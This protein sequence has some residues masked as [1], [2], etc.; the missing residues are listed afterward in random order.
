MTEKSLNLEIG[1][2][3]FTAIMLK[4]LIK[5]LDGLISMSTYLCSCWLCI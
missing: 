1:T 3:F 5:K 4:N 2:V